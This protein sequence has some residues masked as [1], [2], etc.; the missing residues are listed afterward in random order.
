M[1][2]FNRRTLNKKKAVYKHI[3][4]TNEEYIDY[5]NYLPAGE[6]RENAYQ[7]HA[8]DTAYKEFIQTLTHYFDTVIPLRKV[9]INK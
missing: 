7:H 1:N 3:R 6:E 5:L 8:I 9:N 4:V 2:D